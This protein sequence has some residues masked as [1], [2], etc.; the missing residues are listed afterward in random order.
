ML[1]S[2]ELKEEDKSLG[3]EECKGP[4]LCFSRIPAGQ[5]VRP[6]RVDDINWASGSPVSVRAAQRAHDIGQAD[7][8]TENRG[9]RDNGSGKK[10]DVGF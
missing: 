8:G 7:I 1:V 3:P 2:F 5:P 6:L 9:G 4:N 10:L